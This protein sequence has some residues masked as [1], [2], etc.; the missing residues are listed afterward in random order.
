MR[1]LNFVFQFIRALAHYLLTAIAIFSEKFPIT[2]IFLMGVI[3]YVLHVWSGTPL[4]VNYS[5]MGQY[6]RWSF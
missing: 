5:D 4:F 3:I 6:A 1:H 2:S